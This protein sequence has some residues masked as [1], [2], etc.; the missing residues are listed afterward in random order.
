MNRENNVL[1]AEYGVTPVQL[2]AIVFVYLQTQKGKSVCQKDIEKYVNLRASSVSTLLSTLEKNGL[3]NRCVADGD[4]RTK[5][6]SVTEKGRDAC[7][8]NKILMDDCD[9]LIQSALTEEE[10]EAFKNL[11]LKIIATIENQEKEVKK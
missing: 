10:Q 4:A 2:Q 3:I 7:I 9:A 11:L 5:Y 6:I 1:F 8:K